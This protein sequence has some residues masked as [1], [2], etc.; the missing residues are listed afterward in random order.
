MQRWSGSHPLLIAS[1][2]PPESS[3]VSLLK[4][5]INSGQHELGSQSCAASQGEHSQAEGVWKCVDESG[6]Q[7]GWPSLQQ[8]H[9]ALLPGSSVAR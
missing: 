8:H 6:W 4:K 3:S 2:S 1:L 9:L 7:P 5:I